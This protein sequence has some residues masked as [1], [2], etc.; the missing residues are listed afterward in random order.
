[1]AATFAPR[2]VTHGKIYQPDCDVRENESLYADIPKNGGILAYRILKGMQLPLDRPVGSL[3][4]P[5]ARANN[6]AIELIEQYVEYQKLAD[7]YKA[8]LETCQ[9]LLK[10]AESC[11]SLMTA[12]KK[13]TVQPKMT[14]FKGWQDAFSWIRVPEDY[15]VRRH[16]TEPRLDMEHLPLLSLTEEELTAFDYFDTE[17]YDITYEDV[18]TVRSKE[19]KY[20]LPH[21]K[22]ILGTKPL[23]AV[24]LSATHENGF[25]NLDFDVLGVDKDFRSLTHLPPAPSVDYKTMHDITNGRRGGNCYGPQNIR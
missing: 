23:S 19:P 15:P 14:V 9:R 20:W 25:D 24:L 4:T 6:A 12:D 5:A 10:D 1:M 18:K 16:F 21:S 13:M 17:D 3:V 22:Y 11:W 7:S 2:S 8:S